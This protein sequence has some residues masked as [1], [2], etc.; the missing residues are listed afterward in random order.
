MWFFIRCFIKRLYLNDLLWVILTLL[1]LNLFLFIFFL[2]HRGPMPFQGSQRAWIHW[3]WNFNHIFWSDTTT[4][5]LFY[6]WFI[7]LYM[8]FHLFMIC[9][10]KKLC[11]S[12]LTVLLFRHLSLHNNHFP[13]HPVI[14]LYFTLAVL[15]VDIHYH[16]VGGFRGHVIDGRLTEATR[17]GWVLKEGG[18]RGLKVRSTYLVF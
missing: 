12:H 17:F 6:L 13:T 9:S 15:G 16:L 7:L 10:L 2:N 5:L 1:D 8:L 4:L 11:R 3:C 18:L 14:I